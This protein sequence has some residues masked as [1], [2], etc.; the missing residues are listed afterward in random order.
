MTEDKCEIIGIDHGNAQIKTVHFSFPSG[1]V[2][3][4]HEPYTDKN[5]LEYG[6]KYYVCG[7]GR[8]PLL[9]DKTRNDSYYLL[10]LA[11]IAKELEYRNMSSQA[12]IVLGAGLPLTSF[13]R[14]N[15]RFKRYLMRDGEPVCFKFEGKPYEVTISGVYMFPQGYSAVLLHSDMLEGEASVIVAD[16]GGW[17]VDI[18]RLDNRVPNASTCRSLE[19]GMIR[20]FDEISEQIR[21]NLG[22]SMTTAQ[23]EAALRGERSSM[24]ERAKEIV[25]LEGKK[26]AE[27]LISAIL[28][29]GLDV[30]AM[31]VIFMGGGA[32]LMKA[33]VAPSFGLCRPI[34]IDDVC[35]NA[36][37]Y[38]ALVGRMSGGVGNG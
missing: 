12:D 17:T 2:E 18:M 9:S 8:Q 16:I 6:G 15:K 4:E 5:V 25:R 36:K 26:Y 37:G 30:K 38:E 11:A 32:A 13:G 29:C 19:L 27:K 33:H 1:V 14:E 28:E 22:L 23:I 10:T 20:C 35:M 34:I 3:Y 24:D 31:P 7:T 21:R